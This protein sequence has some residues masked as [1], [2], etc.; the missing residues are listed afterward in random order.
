[1]KKSLKLFKTLLLWP[2]I[3]SGC[4]NVS[5]KISMFL[6]TTDDAFINTLTEQI[7]DLF[8]D[9]EMTTY[10]A[11]RSQSVQNRQ[12]ADV[13]DNNEA[14]LLIV[15]IVDRLASRSVVEKAAT[16]NIPII[17]I[18][19][20]PLI[21]D[22]VDFENAFYVGTDSQNEGI[23]QAE[24]A[25]ELFEAEGGFIGSHFDK[26]NDGQLQVVQIKGEQTHQDAEE[27]S[28]YSLEQLR[29]FGYSVD[30]VSTVY[31]DW[32]R[33][34]A[35]SEFKDIYEDVLEETDENSIE[36][37]L[38]NN[39]VMALGVI[40]YLLEREEYDGE[41]TITEQY[42][43][44]IGVDGI[45]LG[46]EAIRAGY[47]YGTVLNESSE[48]A[49]AVYELAT[50]LLSNLSLDDLPYDLIDGKIIRT[51]GEKITAQNIDNI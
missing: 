27:R 10:Y 33:D 12:I 47:L 21:E 20:E 7:V 49:Q 51:Q 42:F 13:V 31:C 2:L 1:M 50:R 9:Y 36:L 28:Y 34:I 14:S 5:N 18:N 44:V 22:I 17:L 3:L 41:K 46:L 37:V 6:Y 8:D 35:Y 39:D 19:R 15:N 11:E 23:L 43:P 30:L 40:D 32:T 25:H 45:E 26:N 4:A 48:Q 24:I 29:S 38:C 16:K